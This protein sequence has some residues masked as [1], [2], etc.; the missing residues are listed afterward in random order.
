MDVILH[1][2]LKNCA[3]GRCRGI[4][5]C[6]DDGDDGEGPASV[7]SV[8]AADHLRYSSWLS[9]SAGSSAY[10][11]LWHPR[12]RYDEHPGDGDSAD[13]S[14]PHPLVG[15]SGFPTRIL[16]LPSVV[17]GYWP[18]VP[19]LIR[20]GFLPFSPKEPCNNESARLEITIIACELDKHIAMQH[21]EQRPGE[22]RRLVNAQLTG[23]MGLPTRQGATSYWGL[24]MGRGCIM[25]FS[26]IHVG[27]D[28]LNCVASFMRL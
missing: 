10:G 2:E 15:Y 24:G 13:E 12:M 3:C 1:P 17:Q 11:I 21:V 25:I 5:E 18:R 20:R 26:G 7:A 8:H 23:Q 14:R 19:Q 28:S 9:I 22:P 16:Y 6:D 27:S 4:A